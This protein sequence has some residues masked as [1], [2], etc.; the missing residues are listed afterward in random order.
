MAENN[1]TQAMAGYSDEKLIT[2]LKQRNDLLHEASYAAVQEAYKRNLIS[3]EEDLQTKYPVP[4]RNLKTER[5]TA[6]Q[7]DRDK[8][9][10]DMIFGALWC[11]GGTIA[12]A[13]DI[14]YIFWGA[15]VFG[16]IQFIRGAMAH[17][18]DE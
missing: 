10:N 17:S 2:L 7:A 12:T 16:G 14:G 15:I 11:V 8:S 1:F 6:S 4:D 9:R 18:G 5:I 13:M 3:G